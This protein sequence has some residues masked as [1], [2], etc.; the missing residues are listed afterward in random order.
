M[1]RLL[2][3]IALWL[4]SPASAEWRVAES[5]HFVIYADDSEKTVRRFAEMLESYHSALEATTGRKTGIP[6]QSNRVTIYAVGSARDIQTPANTKSTTLG[7]FYIPARG[8]ASLSC[9]TCAP[10]G[11]SPT[12]R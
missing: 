8:A 7:G 5:D 1:R 11:E 3:L 12:K 10:P 4:A 6:S 9:R 2:P